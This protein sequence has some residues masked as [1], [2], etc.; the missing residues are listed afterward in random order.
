MTA[1][2]GATESER[3]RSSAG[4]HEQLTCS[5]AADDADL[6]SAA[7]L[8]GDAAQDELEAFPDEAPA[9]SGASALAPTCISW[10]TP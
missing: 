6:L 7:D 1:A 9:C 3:L 5:G 4:A 8:R 10:S 2:C